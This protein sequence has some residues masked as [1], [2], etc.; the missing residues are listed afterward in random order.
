M[1]RAAFEDELAARLR[2]LADHASTERDQPPS[3]PSGVPRRGPTPPRSG[4]LVLTCVVAFVVLVGAVAVIAVRADRHGKGPVAT[5]PDPTTPGPTTPDPTGTVGTWQVLPGDPGPETTFAS[6]VWTGSALLV[7]GGE[8]DA[9]ATVT[10]RGTAFDP[11]TQTWTELLKGPLAPRAGHA[12]V[13]TGTEMVVCCGQSQTSEPSAAAYDPADRTWRSLAAPPIDSVYGAAVWTGS[14]MLVVGG[15]DNEAAAAYDP[16]S[17]TWRLLA[18]PP[19]LIERD[20]D[21][22]WTGTQ[23]LVW[24]RSVFT[25]APGMAYDPATDRWTTLPPLPDDL[26]IDGASMVW[27]GDEVLVWGPETGGD[28]VIGARLSPGDGIWRALAS[29]PLPSFTPHDGTQAST[30]TVWTGREM[31]AVPGSVGP[32]L[33]APTSPTLAYDP[34]TD[35]WRVAASDQPSANGH[36]LIWTGAAT[37]SFGTTLEQLR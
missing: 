15:A 18:D 31:I 32:P 21:A 8:T 3:A 6:V 9:D 36:Q 16:S 19:G 22:A 20:P 5:T 7:W 30:S 26:A 4:V 10:D 25:R 37:F 17:D 11:S 35:S 33:D 29:T 24:P 34:A 14:E 28:R 12:A 27:T 1:T 23:L 2:S 13:W